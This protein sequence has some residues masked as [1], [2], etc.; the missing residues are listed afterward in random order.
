MS[1]NQIRAVIM[2]AAA[3]ATAGGTVASSPVLTPRRLACA[4]V[5]G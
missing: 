4:A 2:I 1:S 5:A 3:A